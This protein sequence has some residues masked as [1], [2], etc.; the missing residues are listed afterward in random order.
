MGFPRMS[1]L[2]GPTIHQP[3]VVQ[4]KKKNI[5]FFPLRN[6]AWSTQNKMIDS[7]TDMGEESL[8]QNDTIKCFEVH[9]FLLHIVQELIK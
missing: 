7:Q 6:E 2:L 8:D 5:V 3:W 1:H 4:R 9:L